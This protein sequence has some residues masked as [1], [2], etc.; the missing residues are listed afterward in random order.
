MGDNA[1]VGLV[2]TFHSGSYVLDLILGG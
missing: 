1:N 2:S